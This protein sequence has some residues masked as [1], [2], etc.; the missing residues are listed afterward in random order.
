MATTYQTLSDFIKKPFGH[1]INSTRNL[2][3]S[4]DYEKLEKKISVASV[5]EIDRSNY[6]VQ[7]KIPSE[8]NVGNYY[9]VVIHFFTD[10][11]DLVRSRTFENY[12]IKFFSNSPSFIY[13]YAALYNINGYLIESL[14][15]KYK[16]EH[17]NS[18]PEQ[19][20]RS[21]DM[22]YDKSIY[23]A[24]RHLL[25]NKLSNL[26]KFTILFKKTKNT[27]KFL[28]D[29]LDVEEVELNNQT[30]SF[31]KSVKKEIKK[32]D[33]I[34]SSMT[35]SKTPRVNKPDS[36]VKYVNAKKPA[37]KGPTKKRPTRSTVKK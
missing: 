24:C 28:D 23:L 27:E 25:D 18:M 8:S 26:N 5:L 33:S 30:K 14:A 22:Y 36:A 19:T 32:N 6:M 9:D 37:K 1:D 12:Y 11:P 17:L 7:I 16:E 29:V 34:L 10:N 21:M 4:V 13:R 15:N 3:L 2:E 35:K 31:E 20:N